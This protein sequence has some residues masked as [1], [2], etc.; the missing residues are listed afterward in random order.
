MLVGR[1]GGHVAAAALTATLDPDSLDYHNLINNTNTYAGVQINAD[2]YQYYANSTGTWIQMTSYWADGNSSALYWVRA[3]SSD[4]LDWVDSGTGSWLQCN[5]TRNWGI[6]DTTAGV[7]PE[8]ASVTIDIATD[9]G[10][11]NIVATETYTLS[12]HNNDP[13]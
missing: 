12:A 9:S 5:T 3:T 1:A 8:T 10:G 11:S 4:T 7:I 13:I 6:V 2:G